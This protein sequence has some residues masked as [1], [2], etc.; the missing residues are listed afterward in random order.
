MTIT[1]TSDRAAVVDTDYYWQPMSTC[2]RAAK[3]QLLGRGGVAVYG[4]WDGKTDWWQ[5]WA[6]LPKKPQEMNSK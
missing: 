1:L 3:V 6:P 2:P 5:G 4:T